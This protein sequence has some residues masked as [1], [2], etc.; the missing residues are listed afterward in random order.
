MPDKKARKRVL[1]IDYGSK[2]AE[3]LKA[4]YEKHQ[5]ERED[6]SYDIELVKAENIIGKDLKGYDIIHQSG[7]RVKKL[8]DE[9]TKYL[10]E[11]VGDDTY[12]IGTC[13][14]AQVIAEHHGIGTK[15]LKKHQKGKKEISYQDEYKEMFTDESGEEQKHIHKHHKWGIPVEGD[16]ESKLEAIATSKQGFHDEKEEGDIYEI[17]RVRGKKQI[18]IQGHGEHGVGKGIM[19]KILDMAHEEYEGSGKQRRKKRI[20]DYVEN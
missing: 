11:S 20:D 4:M 18:G 16:P 1:I 15:K 13:H 9:A 8:S 2:S 5:S 14:G 17:F 10:M 3:N 7:S 12:M 19:Y 6:V